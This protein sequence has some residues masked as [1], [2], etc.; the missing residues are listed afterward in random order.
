L[1]LS[2]LT[3]SNNRNLL[4]SRIKILQFDSSTTPCELAEASDELARWACGPTGT[5]VA[6]PNRVTSGSLP[7]YRRQSGCR[8]RQI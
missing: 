1:K 5:I 4:F 8:S 2:L 6:L 7:S 3:K